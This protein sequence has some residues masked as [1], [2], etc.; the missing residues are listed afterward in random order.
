MADHPQNAPW[1]IR[2][3]IVPYS[4]EYRDAMRRIHLATASEKARTDEKHGRFSLLMYCDEYLDHEHALMLVDDENIPR[5]YILWAE[6]AHVWAENMQPYAEEIRKLGEPYI[7]RVEDGLREYNL[8][9]E[10]YPAHLHIDILE[11]YTGHHHGSMLMKAML[12][13]L[14]Q[15]H[16]KGV[17]LGV[18]RANQRAVSFYLH[19]GFKVLAEDE[20]GFF[21]GQKLITD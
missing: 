21:M 6:D 1:R 15:H 19:N 17:C 13:L 14:R 3:R 10:E 4:P 9:Y 5:G 16:V 11:E 8:A 7:K 20:G 12:N 18:A 2:M